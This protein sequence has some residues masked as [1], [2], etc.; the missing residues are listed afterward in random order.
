MAQRKQ[1]KKLLL[2]GNIE[3]GSILP[4]QNKL[5][6]LL[7]T[8]SDIELDFKKV[9]FVDNVGVNLLVNLAAKLKKKKRFLTLSN[10][11]DNLR[12]IFMITD[13]CQTAKI[14]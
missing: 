1:S 6:K 12:Q 4:I 3:A 10:V 2:D 14:K 13:L 7:E 9:N 11:P 5:N 8:T